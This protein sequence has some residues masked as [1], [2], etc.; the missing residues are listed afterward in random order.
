VRG[1][2]HAQH[3]FDATVEPVKA[4][5]TRKSNNGTDPLA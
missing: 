3:T 2:G 1:N 5:V 4:K